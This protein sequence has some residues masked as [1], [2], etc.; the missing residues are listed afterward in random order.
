LLRRRRRRSRRTS[1]GLSSCL[2]ELRRRI[3]FIMGIVSTM[4]GVV[5]FGWGLSLGLVFGYFVFIYFQPNDVKDP[6]VKPLAELDTKTL[7]ELLPEIPLWVKNPDYDRVSI[8]IMM[9]LP[10]SSSS[11]NTPCCSCSLIVPGASYSFSEILQQCI[12]LRLS[13]D[14]P[15]ERQ[16]KRRSE[17]CF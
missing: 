10:F 9:L 16:R 15:G 4:L 11:S 6:I 17:T 8:T 5:G 3:I 7:Q 13:S 14:P 12:F 1:C 2:Q